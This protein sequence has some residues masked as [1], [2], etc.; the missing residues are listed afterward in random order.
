MSMH[1]CGAGRALILNWEAIDEIGK[2]IAEPSYCSN[3]YLIQKSTG[4][5]NTLILKK[6]GETS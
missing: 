1:I 6:R 2:R 4:C 3:T 5:F